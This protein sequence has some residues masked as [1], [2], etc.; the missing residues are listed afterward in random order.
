MNVCC[1]TYFVSGTK[2][3]KTQTMSVCCFLAGVPEGSRTPDPRF[4][5]PVLYPAELPGLYAE[6][7]HLSGTSAPRA[8]RIVLPIQEA[9]AVARPTPTGPEVSPTCTTGTARISQGRRPK[10]D[11]LK[12]T[13]RPVTLV[14]RFFPDP[15]FIFPATLVSLAE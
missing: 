8:S 11:V 13:R 4:R 12:R 6:P 10:A 5:K 9:G 1:P 2:I 15:P 7:C 3:K 14:E